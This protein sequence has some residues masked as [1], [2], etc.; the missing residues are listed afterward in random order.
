MRRLLVVAVCFGIAGCASGP[1]KKKFQA[2]IQS[3]KDRLPQRIGNFYNRAI[4]MDAA[5]LNYTASSPIDFHE[6]QSRALARDSIAKQVD[7]GS[8]TPDE[9]KLQFSKAA[10]EAH[11]QALGEAHERRQQAFT[12]WQQMNATQN[13]KSVSCTSYKMGMFVNTNCR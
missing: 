12:A 13:A 8:I 7:A 6:A 3:C 4:C 5:E 10:A 2:D 1:D 9:G 11:G